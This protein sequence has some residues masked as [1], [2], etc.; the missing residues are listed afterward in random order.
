MA[1][2]VDLDVIESLCQSLEDVH[3]ALM[4][5]RIQMQQPTVLVLA[6]AHERLIGMMDQVAAHQHIPPATAEIAELQA[7]LPVTHV[8]RDDAIVVTTTE[9]PIAAPE[10]AADTWNPQDAGTDAELV[11]IFL[12]EA[13]EIIDSA[14]ASLQQ[15]IAD[16]VNTLAVESLQRDLHTLKGGARMAEIPPIGDLAHELEFLYEGLGNQRYQPSSG[17]DD[18]LHACHDSLAE[19]LKGL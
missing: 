6:V 7:L 13:Q 10:L 2:D 16:P 3:E 1:G 17:L 14:S 12:E 11:D 15:W 9:V 19:W 8:E 18:L 5:G 4:T